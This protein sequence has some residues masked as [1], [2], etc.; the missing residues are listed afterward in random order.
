MK[1]PSRREHVFG[2]ITVAF[3]T[4]VLLFRYSL[5]PQS[6][7]RADVSMTRPDVCFLL[8]TPEAD[9]KLGD[10]KDIWREDR[11]FGSWILEANFQNDAISTLRERFQWW[12][13]D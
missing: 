13:E 11:L 5:P 3:L 2:L 9:V 10:S 7:R 6:W 1:P 4:G 8:G 12:G